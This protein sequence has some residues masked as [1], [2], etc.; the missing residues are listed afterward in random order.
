MFV[1]VITPPTGSSEPWE[2]PRTNV[3]R[4]SLAPYIPADR[5]TPP[6]PKIIKSYS[7]AIV[8]LV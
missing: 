3:L 1:V 2:C 6:A 7:S 8:I 4:F 5:P